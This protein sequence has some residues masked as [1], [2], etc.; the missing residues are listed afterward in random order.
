MV[1]GRPINL[2]L[3][4]TAGQEDYDRWKFEIS[5]QEWKKKKHFNFDNFAFYQKK[6]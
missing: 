1:D 2:G 6:F 3:W 5:N 4:D